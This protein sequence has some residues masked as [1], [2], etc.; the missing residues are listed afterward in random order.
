MTIT[1]KDFMENVKITEKD[2]REN[3]EESNKLYAKIG[4][5]NI[6]KIY[7]AGPST[8]KEF[9]WLFHDRMEEFPD[10]C[11]LDGVMKKHI[12]GYVHLPQ[13]KYKQSF[14]IHVSSRGEI[15]IVTLKGQKNYRAFNCKQLLAIGKKI[16]KEVMEK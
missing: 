7:F 8:I 16:K 5:R 15:D 4:K 9:F 1:K 14:G 2:Y 6:N 12:C 10:I 3:P 13:G 11:Y